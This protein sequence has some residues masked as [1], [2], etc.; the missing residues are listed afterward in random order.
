MDTDRIDKW[1]WKERINWLVNEF[2]Q[3]V[4]ISP[5]WWDLLREEEKRMELE[6][7]EVRLKMEE[8][9]EKRLTIWRNSI[10]HSSDMI[11]HWLVITDYGNWTNEW[12]V[13]EGIDDIPVSD[14]IG[15]WGRKMDG[16]SKS[17]NGGRKNEWREEGAVDEIEGL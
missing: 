5:I 10:D 4:Q 13:K 17:M 2:L 16:Y 6:W 12:W 14:M 7:E 15:E 8:D 11:I 3:M 1:S 9:E